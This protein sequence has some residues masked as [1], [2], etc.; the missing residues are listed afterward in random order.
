MMTATA[1]LLVSSLLASPGAAGGEPFALDWSAPEGCPS[2]EVARANILRWIGEPRQPSG[3]TA[4]V[5]LAPNPQGGWRVVVE[6]DGAASGR[7]TLDAADCGQAARAASLI[8]AFAL[9]PQA[10]LNVSEELQLA[11]ATTAP[12]A[13]AEPRARPVPPASVGGAAEP[14]LTA[15]RWRSSL[16][17]GLSHSLQ[18]DFSA[19][20]LLGLGL[21]H[22]WLRLDLQGLWSPETSRHT[23]RATVDVSRMGLRSSGCYV[24]DG[25][26]TPLLCVG[27]EATLLDAQGLSLPRRRNPSAW[28]LT[29]LLGT[30]L[31]WRL[32]SHWDLTTLLQ[33]ELPT[34][35]PRFVLE[36]GTLVYQPPALGGSLGVE[37]G[38]RW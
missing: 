24:G 36:D 4:H 13:P 12:P 29:G 5:R 19:Q 8:V 16:G 38:Y 20:L 32:G 9:D 1:F 14:Q 27:A 22:H 11:P 26:L 15:T 23:A 28:L 25:R 31:T 17:A 3:V 21:E 7:R 2:A 37:L 33:G 18:P 30:G 6:L 34:A 35:R 10:A